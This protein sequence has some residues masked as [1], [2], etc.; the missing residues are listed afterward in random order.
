MHVSE[1]ENKLL[2]VV[3]Q[4]RCTKVQMH[5]SALINVLPLS[6]LGVCAPSPAL[7]FAFCQCAHAALPP[8]A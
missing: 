7:T 8:S 3:H 6:I 5:A 1:V 4:R 2:Q